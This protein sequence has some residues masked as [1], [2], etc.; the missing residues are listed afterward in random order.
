MAINYRIATK[1]DVAAMAKLRM[2]GWGTEDY[3]RERITAYL[4]GENNPQKALAPRTVFVAE[5][6]DDIIGFI[7]GHLTR[8]LDCDGELEWIDVT[9]VHRRKGIAREL[10]SRLAEWFIR[11]NAAKICVDPGNESARKFYAALGATNLNAHW[12]YWSDI[13]MLLND[14]NK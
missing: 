2:E 9:Y 6:V 8:R 7:G 1:A 14:R 10:V 11:Q 4:S 13:N 12:M 3:W 5:E